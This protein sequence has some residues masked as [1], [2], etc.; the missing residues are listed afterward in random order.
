MQLVTINFKKANQLSTLL[1]VVS[2]LL[3]IVIK[4]LL[5]GEMKYGLGWWDILIAILCV[6]MGY[7][8]H[9]LVHATAFM[10]VG[11][12]Y[13]NVKFGYDIKKMIIFCSASQPITKGRY[14]FVLIAPFV[15]LGLIP[16]ILSI[17]FLNYPYLFFSSLMIGASAGD[18]TML[19]KLLKLKGDFMVLDHPT[20]PAFYIV[21]EV[22]V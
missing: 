11:V 3:S 18:L 8:I 16:Y 12:R 20:E 17:I 5:C 10:I 19:S 22:D 1:T 2:F 15:I 13:K 7:F 9:E 6:V 4:I 14:K 21:E